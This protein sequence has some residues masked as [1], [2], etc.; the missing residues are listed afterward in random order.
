MS[1]TD[2]IL[3]LFFSLQFMDMYSDECSDDCLEKYPLKSLG[4]DPRKCPGKDHHVPSE[5]RRSNTSPRH[6]FRAANGDLNPHVWYVTCVRVVFLRR[7]DG[8]TFRGLIELD[9]ADDAVA[10]GLNTLMTRDEDMEL[11]PTGEHAVLGRLLSHIMYIVSFNW[12]VLLREAA[13]NI[14]FLVSSPTTVR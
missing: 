6:R 1:Y 5:A 11:S 2:R 10:D 7:P 13:S 8:N 14:Q 9:P 12:T 4:K 3:D